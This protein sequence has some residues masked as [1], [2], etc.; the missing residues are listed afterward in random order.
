MTDLASEVSSGYDAGETGSTAGSTRELRWT[1]RAWVRRTGLGA[2]AALLA[3]M[4]WPDVSPAVGTGLDNSYLGGL[5]MA[6]KMG[7]DFGSEILFT[8]GPLGFLTANDFYSAETS[9]LA[10]VAVAGVQLSAACT[11]LWLFR[12]R[13][14]WWGAAVFALVLLALGSTSYTSFSVI[15]GGLVTT[16]SLTLLLRS[17]TLSRAQ[18]WLLAAAVSTMTAVL[19]L[20]KFN[21]G[22]FAFVI[23][24]GALPVAATLR[25]AGDGAGWWRILRLAVVAAVSLAGAVFTTGLLLW[26]LTGQAWSSLADY[27]RFSW[28]ISE[29]FAANNSALDGIVGASRP[30]SEAR[31]LVALLVIG[32]TTVVVLSTKAQETLPHRLR[33]LAV[34]ALGGC[35]LIAL[36]ALFK[37]GFVRHQGDEFYRG[38]AFV[39]AAPLASVRARLAVPVAAMIGLLLFAGLSRPVEELAAVP[40]GMASL[41][42]ASA[43]LVDPSGWEAE[44]EAQQ[45]ELR[46]QYGIPDTMI[47][48]IGNGTVQVL[49]WE[50][51]A[52]WAYDLNWKPVPVF[53]SYHAYTE[54]LDDLNADSLVNAG[55]RF[56]L[57]QEL[58]EQYKQ[59]TWQSP[60][61]MYE[62]VCRYGVVESSPTWQL[63]ERLPESRC[64]E[65]E[66]VATVDTGSGNVAEIGD[67]LAEVD[68]SDLVVAT[69]EGLDPG[70]LRSILMEGEQFY[71]RWGDQG[72]DFRFVPCT[73]GQF[74]LL[75]LPDE[76]DAVAGRSLEVVDRISFLSGS[77]DPGEAAEHERGATP[78]NGVIVTLWRVPYG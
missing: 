50:T 37:Q 43:V 78:L 64:G 77:I 2:L 44:R 24:L 73:K 17:R 47:D 34:G 39:V 62:V 40:G 23:A 5:A 41:A 6:Q 36:F 7:L 16:W 72:A 38:V 63:L 51:N 22:F 49:P 68:D 4:T 54:A 71:V 69:F 45:A 18:W 15:A 11:Y 57:W 70:R 14:H 35:V 26:L 61:L 9:L 25:W 12:E 8:Y 60:R 55:S 10:F 46:A 29:A 74:H 1:E 52:V 3:V 53:Q 30:L 48:R 75:R 13:L 65:P 66:V 32:V 42:R 27:L 58:G 20:H 33:L 76:W 31:V 21:Y 56:I 67:A 28:Q 19:L 59:P